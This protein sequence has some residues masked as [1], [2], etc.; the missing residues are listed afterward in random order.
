ME[1]K[2]SIGIGIIGVG[3]ICSFGHF[4]AMEQARG[5]KLLALCDVN[6]ETCKSFADAYT[7]PRT[8]SDYHE[9]LADSEI[10]AVLIATPNYLHKTMTIDALKAGKHV[11]SEKPMAF[12]A[13]DAA[14]IV[15]AAR[16]A[17]KKLMIDF[18]HRFW[19][20]SLRLKKEIEAGKL[21]EPYY[22]KI[23]WLRRRGT[24][25]WG[26]NSWFT[27]KRLSG[28][29]CVVDVGCHMAD[30]ALWWLGHPEIAAVTGYTTQR[31][32]H[33]R[34]KGLPEGVGGA[35][36][37]VEDLA[38]ATIRLK[39]GAHI[40]MEVAWAIN[41]DRAELGYADIYG[42]RGSASWRHSDPFDE[43]PPPQLTLYCGDDETCEAEVVELGEE[44]MSAGWVRADQHFIDSI[45]ND[46]EPEPSGECG[47]IAT[48]VTDAIYESSRTGKEVAF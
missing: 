41:L 21:G 9:L 31:F 1:S 43:N 48:R 30:L 19:N 24:P 22:V 32:G 18:T 7:V 12:N 42:T 33:W 8:Y 45:V 5:A 10:D 40:F 2:T 11:L 26:H 15:A 13:A 4:P 47:L 14:E 20:R 17:K 28:G 16:A 38:A 23:G 44:S 46:R 36:N 34:P 37:D 39:N 35:L 29:G 6:A 27:Q 3:G 25:A